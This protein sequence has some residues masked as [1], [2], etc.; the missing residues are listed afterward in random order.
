MSKRFNRYEVVLLSL[1]FTTWGFVF[2]DRL[3]ISF[4]LPVIAPILRL[5]N[6]Q[7]GLIGLVTTGCFAISAV[8]FGALSD[9]S[10][11][12]KRWLIPFVFATAVFSALCSVTQTFDQLLIMRGLVGISEG[13]LLTIMMTMLMR[14]SSENQFG[15]NAGIVNF[16]VGIIAITFGPIFITQL[17][18]VTSWQMTFLIS[19]LPT[20][21][22]GFLLM[23]FTHEVELSQ[24]EQTAAKAMSYAAIFEVFKYR[25]IVVCIIVGITVMSGYWALVLF[26]PLYWVNIAHISVQNM[27]FLSGSAGIFGLLYGVAIPKLS[28]NF[29]RKPVL[30]IT[31][32]ACII[33]PLTM[34][35]MPGSTFSMGVYIVLSAVLGCVTPI[36]FT[37][38]PMETV[39]DRLK[40]TAGAVI[41]GFGEVVG[42]AVFPAI[43]GS[44]ADAKG[45]P[46]MMLLAAILIALG[47]IASFLIIETH[48]RKAKAT[49]QLDC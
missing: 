4:L 21:I 17:V 9:K 32:I 2:L 46:F 11:Y 28:D 23:K 44:I 26:A 48:P 30:S 3:A 29:G 49:A 37:L 31:L 34:Y 41:V 22:L 1:F 18:S 10:G 8:V 19:A 25:N 35:L 5:S 20:F 7:V 13:P 45:L 6:G 47:L 12:R 42:G 24:E 16:G 15:R 33:L 43:G 38:I 36:F 14:T 39:P 27:G 40:A